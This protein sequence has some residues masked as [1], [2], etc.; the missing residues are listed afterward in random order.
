M[1]EFFDS[2]RTF[3]KI[4]NKEKE[5]LT[6]APARWLK[7]AD[8]RVV[9]DVLRAAKD[10]GADEFATQLL[11]GF[12]KIESRGSA[13]HTF[14]NPDMEKYRG[15]IKRPH[16]VGRGKGRRPIGPFQILQGTQNSYKKRYGYDPGK[17]GDPYHQAEVVLR[18]IKAKR[19]KF[20]DDPARIYIS[21]NQ[22]PGGSAAIY[23]ALKRDPNAK[24]GNAVPTK[25]ARNMRGNF[26]HRNFKRYGISNKHEITPGMF[27]D[28]YTK[29]LGFKG[30][31]PPV[32][33]SISKRTEI[34]Q[35][36]TTPVSDVS[37]RT[38]KKYVIIAGNSHAA[39]HARQ[40]KRRYELLSQKTGIEYE[41]IRI[42]A[43]QGG[44]GGV[45]RLIPKME[46]IR[47]K[48][49]KENVSVAAVVHVGTN[50][51]SDAQLD[52][53]LGGYRSM[54]DNVTFVGSPR[55]RSGYKGY[56]KRDKWNKSL[57]K[58]LRDQNINYINTWDLTTDDDLRGKDNVH[59]SSKA[60]ARVH[61]EIAKNIILDKASEPLPDYDPA[62]GAARITVSRPFIDK[63]TPYRDSKDLKSQFANY[64]KTVA[65]R[66]T[67]AGAPPIRGAPPPSAP[68]TWKQ[69][70]A[71]AQPKAYGKFVHGFSKEEFPDFDF[72]KFYDDLSDR[73][74]LD[75]LGGPGIDYKFG[76]KHKI[77]Y[78][79]LQK[80]KAGEAPPPPAADLAQT[81]TADPTF[82]DWQA[83][84]ADP[85]AY[86]ASLP[87]APAAA[88]E[89][90]AA[91]EVATPAPE[92]TDAP[93]Q[94]T[95]D[96][97]SGPLAGLTKALQGSSLLGT[98][99][100]A[101]MHPLSAQDAG[102]ALAKQFARWAGLPGRGA[103]YQ[104]QQSNAHLEKIIH[105][106]YI[107]L[108]KEQ[109]GSF[110]ET[111]QV[112]KVDIILRFEKVFTF[113]GNVLN[114][115]RAIKGITIAR[116]DE[117][118]LIEMYPDK[119]AVLLHLKFI[120]DRPINQY[121]SYLRSELSKINDNDGDK[122]LGINIQNIP[123]KIES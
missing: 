123:E 68:P 55:A 67:A 119:Q 76:R 96:P 81:Y 7:R 110:R 95:G 64:E 70:K 100:H 42:D 41:I 120:P 73:G 33:D 11:L 63:N 31:I 103:I 10:A 28:R 14:Y 3:T 78:D 12:L 83:A 91:E 82:A 105:E 49:A 111:K 97:K 54:T 116:A 53:L 72:E 50:R 36:E 46:I 2:W 86:L 75:L 16:R 22:G 114:Q 44:G 18:Y 35:K 38:D 29:L 52:R 21:W 57:E 20:G 108:L 40:L 5:L 6:E 60:Y 58:R 102:T 98:P 61:D 69:A 17:F 4:P 19:K 43:I 23:R 99:V 101:V 47:D 59:L 117:A 62:A 89:A 45:A 104:E 71:E 13:K 37:K 107:K 77:A 112:I 8:Q 66:P 85:E 48:I 109:E 51:V 113:Y 15:V 118:G 94:Q 56:D 74:M 1:Q 24:I 80:R 79:A 34:A 25:I 9:N 121:L 106:E 30:D 26:S 90:P 65:S 87:P 92:P 122:I 93:V 84:A 27:V 88:E 115:I 32:D 39:P